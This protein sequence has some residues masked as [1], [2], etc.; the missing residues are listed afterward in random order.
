M[1]TIITLVINQIQS[2]VSL[3]VSGP[4]DSIPYLHNT[5]CCNREKESNV[6]ANVADNVIILLPKA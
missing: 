4:S 5:S 1:Y 2:S 3:V 6:A